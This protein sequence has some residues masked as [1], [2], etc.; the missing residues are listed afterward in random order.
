MIKL[1]NSNMTQDDMSKAVFEEMD[2]NKVYLLRLYTD[3][4]CNLYCRMERYHA[5]SLYQLVL[6][7]RISVNCWPSRLLTFLSQSNHFY[8]HLRHCDAFVQFEIKFTYI[9]KSSFLWT[10]LVCSYDS[11]LTYV[12]LM[13]L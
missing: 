10:A 11:C 4:C 13:I 6:V 3:P 1:Q 5:K 7:E 9:P 2:K 12:I 8:Y